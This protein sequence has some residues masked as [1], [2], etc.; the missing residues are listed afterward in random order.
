[1]A[2]SVGLDIYRH[3]WMGLKNKSGTEI[4]PVQE[5]VSW[6]LVPQDMNKLTMELPSDKAH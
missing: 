4:F 3:M 2:C 1:M 6:N 5:C